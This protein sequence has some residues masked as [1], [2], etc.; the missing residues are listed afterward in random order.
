MKTLQTLAFILLLCYN[1][2]KNHYG[3][4]NMIKF[5]R[6]DFYKN[7]YSGIG[8]IDIEKTIYGNK[9]VFCSEKYVN[10]ADFSFAL[11]Y[12]YLLL[13]NDIDFE[14]KKSA[15]ENN[16][17]NDCKGTQEDDF[18][19]YN[20]MCKFFNIPQRNKITLN[21]FFSI[22]GLSF[23]DFDEESIKVYSLAFENVK[24]SCFKEITMQ[25]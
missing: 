8:D 14:I 1:L 11:L 18:S 12:N 10:V 3:D 17:A 13:K 16:T 24:K 7:L 6:M 25:A 20:D 2:C 22:F 4:K 9:L 21:N 5:K 23:D 19:I 15:K